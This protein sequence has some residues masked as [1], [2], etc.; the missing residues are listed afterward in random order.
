MAGRMAGAAGGILSYFTRHGTAANL[1][2][3][4]LIALGLAAVPR[5]RAQFFPDVIVDDVTVNVTWDGAGADDV[6]AGITQVLEPVLLAV[7]GVEDATSRSTEG[8]ANIDLS[9]EPGWDMARAASDVQAAVDAV[10]ELPEEADEPTV[11]RGAWRDRVTDV[12]ITGPVGVDQLGRFAD[13]F[14]TRLFAA[15]VTRT[16]IR[17]LAAPNTIVEVPSA[18]LVRHDVTMAQ[19]ADAIEAAAETSPAGDVSGGSARVRTGVA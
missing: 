2:L 14:V 8:R 13:E 17:G 18:A 9:F 16:T 15:G 6:D 3:V 1:L 11:R 12:V 10:T 19:I 7:E 5:M 4:I